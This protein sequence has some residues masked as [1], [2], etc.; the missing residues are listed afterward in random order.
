VVAL[1]TGVV[2]EFENSFNAVPPVGAANQVSGAPEG[3]VAER[4]IVPDPHL[5]KLLVL[6]GVVGVVL[7]VAIT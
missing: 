4:T 3:E 2:Y 5:L 7:I 1:I 6:V